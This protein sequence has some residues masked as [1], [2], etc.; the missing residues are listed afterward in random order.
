VANNVPPARG[1]GSRQRSDNHLR[2]NFRE[3]GPPEASTVA[4]F[5]SKWTDGPSTSG[6]SWIRTV[7]VPIVG[8]RCAY[9]G[10]KSE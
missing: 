6:P 3:E 10:P 1:G 4:C 7:A 8:W 5:G 2:S 9:C